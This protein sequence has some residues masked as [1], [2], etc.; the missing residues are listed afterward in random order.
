MWLSSSVLSTGTDYAYHAC[1]GCSVCRVA[2]IFRGYT[3]CEDEEQY[4]SFFEDEYLDEE[5]AAAWKGETRDPAKIN[6]G[7]P[8]QPAQQKDNLTTEPNAYWALM[9]GDFNICAAA[10]DR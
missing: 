9:V 6:H 2:P 3:G 10:M 8:L 4:K 5:E 1:I 7:R